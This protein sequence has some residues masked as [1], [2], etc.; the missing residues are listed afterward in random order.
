MSGSAWANAP[1]EV[2]TQVETLAA[3]IKHVLDDALVGIYVHGSLALGCFNPQRSDVD[4]LVV[5]RR[6]IDE[7]TQWQLAPVLLS[8]STPRARPR[9]APY[10]LEISF[11]TE[12]QLR[13]WRYPTPYDVH[14]SES[15]RAWVEAGEWKRGGEDHDLAAHI[16]VV[17]DAGIALLGPDPREVFPEVP[18][19]DF[20]DSLLRDFDW[21][22]EQNRSLYS[23]L[24]GSRIWAAL[25]EGGLH[26]KASGAEWALQRAPKE[27]GPLI[28]R[29]LALYRGELDDEELDPGDVSRYLDFLAARVR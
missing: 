14:F 4:V 18:D 20:E 25:T 27:F 8:S 19:D 28:D 26:S 12:A 10:P 24:S 22:R 16:R 29:A 17:R 23:V 11:L 6:T 13:P 2:R 5:T 9:T 3:G 1:K 21:S 7:R 15:W